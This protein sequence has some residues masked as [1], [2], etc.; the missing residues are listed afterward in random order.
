MAS[1]RPDP[2][3]R[4]DRVLAPLTALAA[5]F[6]VVVLLLGPELIGAKKAGAQ[7]ATAARSGKQV[8]TAEGCGGCH[9]LAAAG[10]SGTTGPDLDQLKPDA[11]TVKAKVQSGG[12]SM[13][14]FKL[15][16]P[17]LDALAQ[18]VSSVAGR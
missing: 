14:S 18:Y 12:G 8:F 2:L 16:A 10:T 3:A 5:A 11:A 4:V 13:P 9:T 1:P 15:P 7:P 6:A 17:E